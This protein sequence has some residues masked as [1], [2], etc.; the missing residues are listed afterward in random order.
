MSVLSSKNPI[1]GIMRG[2]YEVRTE[3]VGDGP[4]NIEALL[5]VTIP[6]PLEG[7]GIGAA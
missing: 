6:L 1:P 3:P 4:V 5:L 7:G 2:I